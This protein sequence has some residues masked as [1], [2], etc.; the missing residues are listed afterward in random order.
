ML[1]NA[2]IQAAFDAI[3]SLSTWLC[4]FLLLLLGLQCLSQIRS[5][6]PFW[7]IQ[8]FTLL[9]NGIVHCLICLW[10]SALAI[11]MFGSNTTNLSLLQNKFLMLEILT[12]VSSLVIL[13]GF[14]I[15][16]SISNKSNLASGPYSSFIIRFS[17]S[18]L[19]STLGIV[20]L[21]IYLSI[22]ISEPILNIDSIEIVSAL[23]MTFICL[24][25][26]IL[27][28]TTIVTNRWINHRVYRSSLH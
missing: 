4:L 11:S 1:E 14:L 13:M 6:V 18:G 7:K 16:K 20:S 28:F 25:I 3:L 17:F 21:L 5:R 15:E 19:I 24:W 2:H 8:K 27:G 10:V 26:I 12:V 9:K 22:K 23:V